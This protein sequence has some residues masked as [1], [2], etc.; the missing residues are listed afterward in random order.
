MTT[1]ST[2]SLT[3][4]I[5]ALSRP[6]AYPWDVERVEVCQ[7][8]I[9]AV[10]LAGPW[11]IKVKKPVRLPF[12]DFSTLERRQFFCEEE[13]RLNQRLAPGVY[14]GVV[15]ITRSSTGLRIQGDG[16]V[17]EWAVQMERLPDEATFDSRLHHDTLT[18]EHVQRLARRVSEFHQ[19]ARRDQLTA[20][21]G[22]FD[23]IAAAV[24][25]NLEFARDQVGLTLSQSVF[26]RLS[27]VT[28]RALVLA[29]PIIE[30]RAEAGFV[31]ELHGDLH[32]DHVYLLEDQPSPRDLLIIDTIEFNEGFRCIDVVADMAFCVIDFAAHGRRDLGRLFADTYFAATGDA[33][34]RGLLPLFTSY[35]A[36]VRAKVNGMLATESEVAPSDRQAAVD[37]ATALWLLALGE[38]ESPAKRPALLLVSGLPGTGKSTLARGLAERAG[39]RVIRSDVVRKELAG[40]TA[41]TRSSAEFQ[42]GIY[43]PAWTDRTYAECLR[44]ATRALLSGERVIVDATFLED[45]RRRAF[46]QAAIRLGVPALWLV[47][48]ALEECVRTRLAA[49]HGDASDADW[50]IYQ[51]AAEHWENP[52][53][54][55]KRYQRPISTESSTDQSLTNALNALEEVSDVAGVRPCALS[56]SSKTANAHQVTT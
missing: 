4:L 10:F 15:P 52:S 22:R 13:V 24:R 20:T 7:T 11:V 49:R 29:Q 16:P 41:T 45:D 21:Y 30:R 23:V 47:C 14:H 5:A 56:L 38:L 35:R 25:A 28:E 27:D 54:F 3:E 36:A 6:T 19:S 9:S 1:N 42:Q 44:Q 31:R 33:E 26:E 39:F 34:G 2:T 12:L 8:H 46:L 43:S 51:L 37:R 55:C 18:T 40:L 32:L 50:S 17:A 48:E 53:V